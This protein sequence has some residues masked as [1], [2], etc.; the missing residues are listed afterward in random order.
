M[1]PE[2][3]KAALWRDGDLGY[4]LH[5]DQLRVR[6]QL[7]RLRK[8]GH[9]LA[10]VLASR[11][12]GK[13]YLAC[14]LSHEQ[15]RQQDGSQV[16]YAAPT[17]KMVRTIVEPHMQA[18]IADAPP[19]IRPAHR[20]MDG[21]WQHPNG[22]QIHTAGTDNG[23][24]DRLRGVSTDL[25][26]I[27]EAGFID[28]LPYLLHDVLIP[29]TATTGGFLFCISS[30]SV[31]P[32]HAFAEICARADAD[33]TLI[34]R[35]IHDAPHIDEATREELIHIAGGPE[36][37][38]ARREYFC[39]FVADESMVVL[40]EFSRVESSVV[41]EH[42]RP[43]HFVPVVVMDVGYHDLSFALF[44]YHDFEN[45]VDVIEH[46]YVTN[47]TVARAL[48]AECSKIAADLWGEERAAK[49]LRWADAPPMVLAEM[50]GWTGI[51]KTQTDGSF[52]AAAVNDVRTR[53]QD[54]TI[55][56]SLECRKLAAHCRFAVWRVPGRDLERMDGFG[57]FDGVD[58]LTYF[59]RLVDRRTNPK[60]A[61]KPTADSVLWPH[62]EKKDDMRGLVAGARWK[63]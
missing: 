44:G 14:T 29:Q 57:H 10:V 23:G 6:E 18:L 19:D 13:D 43:E 15:C 60:P 46:E 35:T 20:V 8:Q 16:R 36:S 55:R 5:E 59:V 41:A 33:G 21:I 51:A 62:G 11:R 34:K 37:T 22:S 50:P 3:A 7:V 45:A 4:V 39:E 53:L 40:P 38:T 24:A 63:R 52:K 17:Q 30:A 2:Q 61:R 42:K 26:P 25:A 9:R 56:I 58:A 32:A 27:S 48:D 1:T 49:A 54:K 12:W 47:K 31:T 28:C